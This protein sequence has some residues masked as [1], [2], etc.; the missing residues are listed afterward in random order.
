MGKSGRYPVGARKGKKDARLRIGA[1]RALHAEVQN[2]KAEVA[3]TNAEKQ[4]LLT[5]QSAL[6]AEVGRLRNKVKV[7]EGRAATLDAMVR[8][9]QDELVQERN[10][11][12]SYEAHA[13]PRRHRRLLED[14]AS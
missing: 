9:L 13:Q 14:L 11:R 12:L 8:R 2:A 6:Q 10:L 7:A 3:K 1:S 4:Q 5:D